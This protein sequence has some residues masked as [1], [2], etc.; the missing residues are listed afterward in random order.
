MEESTQVPREAI[1]LFAQKV[2]MS[3]QR[4]L[5]QCDGGGHD[6]VNNAGGGKDL[7]E[8]EVLADDLFG[9]EGQFVD[10]NHRRDRGSFDPY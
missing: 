9:A 7:E 1:G 10:E 5:T 2:E 6:E 3:L 8:L 4:N